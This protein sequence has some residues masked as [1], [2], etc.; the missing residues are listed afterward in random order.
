M[1]LPVEIDLI[2]HRYLLSLLDTLRVESEDCKGRALKQF[3]KANQVRENIKL[4]KQQFQQLRDNFSV[5]R[6]L[7]NAHNSHRSI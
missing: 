5:C 6:S 1:A 4:Y 7:D 3:L 2:I